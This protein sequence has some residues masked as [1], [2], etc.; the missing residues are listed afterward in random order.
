MN[1]RIPN[2]TGIDLIKETNFKPDYHIRQMAYW[3]KAKGYDYLWHDNRNTVYAL[4][5]GTTKVITLFPE[6]YQAIL[7]GH[8]P[9]RKQCLYCRWPDTYFFNDIIAVHEWDFN[10]YWRILRRS[11]FNRAQAVADGQTAYFMR[12]KNHVYFFAYRTKQGK[13]EYDD[14]IYYPLLGYFDRSYIIDDFSHRF[15]DDGLYGTIKPIIEEESE[16]WIEEEEEDIEVMSPEDENNATLSS[17]LII[18]EAAPLELSI[19]ERIDTIL[20]D[21]ARVGLENII[22]EDRVFL[23]ACARG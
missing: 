20:E 5:H 3:K 8:F 9:G 4:R 22:P 13:I 12:A 18:P 15:D 19:Y 11:E 16:L 2:L 6:Y 7:Q 23:E 17:T 1:K 21:I 14:I 10:T